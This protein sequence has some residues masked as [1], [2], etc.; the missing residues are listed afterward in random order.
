LRLI[1]YVKRKS[2]KN[3]SS[4]INPPTNKAAL[5]KCRRSHKASLR[6]IIIVSDTLNKITE[7]LFRAAEDPVLAQRNICLEQDINLGACDAPAS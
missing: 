2:T 5:V 1:I 4:G 7:T 6:I 3:P